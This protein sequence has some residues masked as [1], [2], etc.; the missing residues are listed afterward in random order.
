MKQLEYLSHE[1]YY[2]L[3]I[4]YL[5]YKNTGYDSLILKKFIQINYKIIQKL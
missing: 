3:K 2:Q 5:F 4:T 1:Y